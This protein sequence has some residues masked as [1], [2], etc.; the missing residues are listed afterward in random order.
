[1][2]AEDVDLQKWVLRQMKWLNILG[3]RYGR[4]EKLG[5]RV[6][7]IGILWEMISIGMSRRMFVYKVWRAELDL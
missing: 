6:A 2:H 4:K 3:L 7:F 1:M 5:C